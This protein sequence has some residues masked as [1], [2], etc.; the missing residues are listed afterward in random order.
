MLERG[1]DLNN[2]TDL[3][4][5]TDPTDNTEVIDLRQ[6]HCVLRERRVETECRMI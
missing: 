1:T 6:W 2:L 4:D 3:A 5:L